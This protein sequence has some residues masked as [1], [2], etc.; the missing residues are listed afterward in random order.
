MVN[1]YRSVSRMDRTPSG[2]GSAD[3]MLYF[4]G[5]RRDYQYIHL[6]TVALNTGQI[7]KH[8]PLHQFL[9]DVS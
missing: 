2:R 5:A 8:H 6:I 3:S 4:C 1:L 7:N 9:N